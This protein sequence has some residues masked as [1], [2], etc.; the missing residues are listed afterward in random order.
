MVKRA[1]WIDRLKHRHKKRWLPKAVRELQAVSDKL[2]VRWSRPPTTNR[3]HGLPPDEARCEADTLAGGRCRRWRKK[4]AKVCP[5][6][7]HALGKRPW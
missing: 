6:H 1:R 4:S 7:A 5:L 3:A 2:R